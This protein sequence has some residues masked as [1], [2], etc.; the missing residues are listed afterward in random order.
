MLAVG[1]YLLVDV[2]RA[3][4]ALI[5][6][7]LYLVVLGVLFSG[8]HTAAPGPWVASVLALYPAAAWVALT[9][10]NTED[11]DQRAVTTAAA[12]GP[13]VVT[14]AVLGVALFVDVALAVVA[15]AVPAVTNPAGFPPAALAVGALA[16]LAAAATGTAVGLVCARPVIGRIG[17]SFALSAAIVVVTAVQPW[18]PPVG[19]AARALT[20]PNPGPAVVAH[21]LLGLA[22]AAA[23]AIISWTASRRG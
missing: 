14:A 11:P 15:V 13:G 2:L 1:R 10:A 4:R 3:Q 5:P 12:G 22:L 8:D 21:T 16:H 19:S 6:I 9:V 18:L 17:W 7:V 20:A 23:A